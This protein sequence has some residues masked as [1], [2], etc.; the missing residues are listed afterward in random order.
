AGKKIAVISLRFESSS[1]IGNY[2]IRVGQIALFNGTMNTPASPSGVLVE[3]MTEIDPEKATLRLR[4]NHSPDPIYYYNV[5]RRNPDDSLTYL[6]GTPNNAYFVAEINRV[7]SETTTLIEVE[8]VGR[9][10]GH[11]LRATTTFDWDISPSPIN[12]ALNKPAAGSTPCN[13]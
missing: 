3:R 5:Y 12:L 13:A 6:G 10:F 11:S 2:S 7:G 1:P 4:W 8:A 9:E